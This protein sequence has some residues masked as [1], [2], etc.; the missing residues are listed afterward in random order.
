MA[1]DPLQNISPHDTVPTPS[2]AWGTGHLPPWES[3]FRTTAHAIFRRGG[4]IVDIGGGLRIAEGKCN[5]VEP[6]KQRE[7]APYLQD[8]NVRYCVTD[9]TDKYH[10]DRVEDIH[11]LSFADASVD[12]LFCIA[13]LEHVEEPARAAAELM[14]VLRAGGTGLIYVPFLYRYHAHG[15]GDYRDFWR[16]SKDG[17]AHLFAGCATAE[18]CPVRG[19]FESL[20][21][22]TPF[23]SLPL[24]P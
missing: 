1:S 8:P 5:K 12:G 3:F 2:F 17:I 24:L 21:R 15:G 22:F 19:L 14:R 7:Y 4:H 9:Y 6:G 13:V 11:R 10:P 20:L 18:L 16:F 23:H